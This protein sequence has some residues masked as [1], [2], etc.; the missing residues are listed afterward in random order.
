M[1][2]LGLTVTGNCPYCSRPIVPAVSRLSVAAKL[3]PMTTDPADDRRPR[4]LR[5]DLKRASEARNLIPS[6]RKHASSSAMSLPHASAWL[7]RPQARAK[8]EISKLLWC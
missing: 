3:P 8:Y 5:R 6:D 2:Q 7:S 1:R 4:E